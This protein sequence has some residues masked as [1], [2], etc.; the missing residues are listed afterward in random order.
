MSRKLTASSSLDALKKEAKRWLK[1]VRADEPDAIVRLQQTLPRADRSC[2]LR[3]VQQALAREYGLESWAALTLQLADQALARRTHAERVAEFLEHAIVNYGIVPEGQRWDGSYPDDPARREYAARILQRHPEIVRGSLHAAAI[4]G[5]VEEVR[6]LLA[7][8]R[9]A[10]SFPGGI[11]RWEPLLYLAYSRLPAAAGTENAPAIA[12][13]L[14]D[15]GADPNVQTTD[16]E[17]PFTAVTGFIGEGERTPEQTP[18]HPRAEE[19]VRLLIARGASPFDTQALYNTSLWLDS[20]K[21]LEL[22]YAHDE[23]TGDVARWNAPA[24]GKVRWLDYLLGNAVDREHVRRIEWL[25]AHGANPRARHAYTKRNLHTNAVLHGRAKAAELLQNA[26]AE[27][28][29]LAG[30]EAFQA[31]CLRQD[32]ATVRAVAAEHPEYLRDAAALLTAATTGNVGAVELLLDLG[33]SPNVSNHGGERALHVAAWADSIPVA[34]LLIERGAEVDARDHRFDSTPLGWAIHL[35]KPQL[36]EFL[37]TVSSDVFS[38]AL[39]GR[40]DRLRSVLQSQPAL[41]R[42]VRRNRTP[43]FCS[44]RDEDLA[45]EIAAFFLSSGADPSIRNGEGRTAADESER[46]GMDALAQLLRDAEKP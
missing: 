43:L 4:A 10:V 22:L 35:G 40:V 36:S 38:L 13:L 32:L 19:M 7:R 15:N 1:A 9:R 45:M 29:P 18:P 2:G 16:G 44:P 20:T 31:A 24:N 42:E 11:R 41:A 6:R 34:Q 26:G 27:P 33:V 14:L 17:N 37:S 5:D 25:L 12:A 8:E 30:R 39:L 28:E 23:S 3:E 46:N 21:W